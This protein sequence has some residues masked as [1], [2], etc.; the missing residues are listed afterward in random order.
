MDAGVFLVESGL[1][2]LD[3]QEAFR[4]VVPREELHYSLQLFLSLLI[5]EI[6]VFG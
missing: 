6:G 4:R 5:S 1:K 3:S 2:V